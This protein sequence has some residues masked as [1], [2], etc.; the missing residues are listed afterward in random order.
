MSV[1][2]VCVSVYVQQQKL[3]MSDEFS[4]EYLCQLHALV[5]AQLSLLA[6][7]T[8]RPT[9]TAHV[10]QVSHLSYVVCCH[11]TFSG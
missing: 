5:A 8:N 10:S 7:L 4:N 1:K 9:F 2:L 11:E 6:Q 3:A